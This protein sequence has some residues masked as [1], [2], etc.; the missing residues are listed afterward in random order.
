MRM[1]II[2]C[3]ATAM[4]NLNEDRMIILTRLSVSVAYTATP[5]CART[6]SRLPSAEA[7]T[8]P[9]GKLRP[10]LGQGVTAQLQNSWPGQDTSGQPEVVSLVQPWPW[11]RRHKP[12]VKTQAF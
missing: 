3:S 10:E 1:T 6:A 8:A 11:G 5:S 12:V 9:A 4:A 7:S 2:A